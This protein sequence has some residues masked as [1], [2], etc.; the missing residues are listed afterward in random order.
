MIRYIAFLRALNTGKNRSVKMEDL[1]QVFESLGFSQ[2]TTVFVS[3]NVVFETD[4]VDRQ[5]L[6][7]KIEAALRLVLGFEIVTF[8]RTCAETATVAAYHPFPQPV[9]DSAAEYNI[10]FLAEALEDESLNKL[11]VLAD[12]END[13]RVHGSEVYWLRNALP[14]KSTFSTLP[15]AKA[16]SRPFTIRTAK[17]VARIAEKFC[18]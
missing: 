13:F 4:D 8:L 16:L 11:F 14:G 9:I 2:L 12:N 17:I 15:L 5:S 6:Q 7:T 10:I 1:R 18:F 3:G